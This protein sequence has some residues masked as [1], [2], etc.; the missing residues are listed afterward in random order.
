MVTREVHI[1]PADNDRHSR[2]GPYRHEKERPVFNVRVGVLGEEDAETSNADGCQGYG[3]EEA[4]AEEI[5]EVGHDQGGREG[6]GPGRDGTE[7]DLD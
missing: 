7:L 1:E 4:V 3:E 2:I 5:A 6:G